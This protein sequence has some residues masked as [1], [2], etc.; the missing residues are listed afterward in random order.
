M[1]LIVC[2]GAGFIGSEF[3][4]LSLKDEFIE[5][6]FV[7]DSLTYAG[8]L[9]NL[10][11]ASKNEKFEFLQEDIINASEYLGKFPK[12]SVLVNFAAES[13][14]DKSISEPS[15]SIRTN[16]L[17]V[18]SLL[19]SAMH[20]GLKR[21]I[22]VSTDEVYG[23]LESG[24]AREDYP[25]RPSSPYS[26]SKASADLLTL[27]YWHTY[28]Y[29]VNITRGANTFGRNQ[30]PEK[31]IPLALKMLRQGKKVPIYGTGLQTREWLHVTNHAEGIMAT[32]KD[33]IPG[34]VYNL[35]S[36][37]RLTNLQVI[38][39]LCKKLGIG[40]NEIEFVEDRKGHDAR[41]ALNSMKAAQQLGWRAETILGQ[42]FPDFEE[43]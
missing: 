8:S 10:D 17:G 5:K 31:L 30:Y 19:D 6:V 42:D 34:E 26:A 20:F 33:G 2:G 11:E 3:V 28:K 12:D 36:G 41:Y 14:V 23:S 22:Q 15:K 1:K 16:V 21:F 35:G 24:E 40:S 25:L 4:N 29:P 38:Q 18:A 37:I 9:R 39:I 13:H 32:V 7:V 27:A 43:W